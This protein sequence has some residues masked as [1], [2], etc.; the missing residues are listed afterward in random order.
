MST[1][2]SPVQPQTAPQVI[3]QVA[4]SAAAAAAT[5]AAAAPRSRAQ[6]LLAVADAL[7]AAAP[8]LVPLAAAETGLDESR[9]TAE[10]KRAVLQWRLFADVVVDGAHLE[11]RIDRADPDFVLGPRPD[12][13]RYLAP[14]GP[15]LNFAAGNFP[16]AFSVPGGDT[17]SALAAGSPVIVKAHPGHAR[18]SHRVAQIITRALQGLGA[19]EGTFALIVGNEPGVQMLRD[20]RIAAA[21][22]TGSQRVGQ[23]LAQIAASRPE[24]I[25]F[26]GELGSVNP[27][28][29][30]ARALQERGP[31]MAAGFA[32]SMSGSAGQ[33]CT[34]PGLVFVPRGSQFAARAADELGGQAEH[35]LLTPEITDGFRRRRAAILQVPGVEVIVD[36]EIRVHDDLGWTT[37]TLVSVG[38]GTLRAHRAHLLPEAFGPLAIVVEYDDA[39]ALPEVVPDLFDGELTATLHTGTGERS[40]DLVALAQ[41]LAAHAG[42]VLFN[43]WPTG[44]AVTPAMQHGGPWPATTNDSNTSVGTAAISRFLRPVAYQDAPQEWLPP[45][46]RDENPWGV[47]QRVAPPGQSAHWGSRGAG[48]T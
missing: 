38:L 10:L 25:P 43:G 17:V 6:A 35:R 12:V 19:P 27:V 48:R 46:L 47:P 2:A 42:R 45:P 33:L 24:P 37:P 39:A 8:E 32:R 41:V 16:F 1:P 3:A 7:A 18:L 4:A 22:F 31:E 44:V 5:W 9:L 29:V 23:L 20:R 26:Y 14:I 30:T 15:V 21:T 36:G 11:V 34:K 13:R 28:F 40:S